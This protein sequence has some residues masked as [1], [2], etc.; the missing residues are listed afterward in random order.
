MKNILIEKCE[1]KNRLI[2]PLLLATLVMLVLNV[3][4]LVV[5][6]GDLLSTGDNVASFFVSFTSV[7][8]WWNW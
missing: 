6:E 4:Y 7:A 8:F 1:S 5:M 3:F 2:R